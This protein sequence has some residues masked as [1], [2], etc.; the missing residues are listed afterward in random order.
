MGWRLPTRGKS[1]S[2]SLFFLLRKTSERE[3]ILIW[4]VEHH[5][6]QDIE[7]RRTGGFFLAEKRFTFAF[8]SIEEDFGR[9]R[10]RIGRT[11]DRIRQ[12]G[13]YGN[14]ARCIGHRT[15]LH[16]PLH[17]A[18]FLKT[19]RRLLVRCAF[20]FRPYSGARALPGGQTD[21]FISLPNGSW[22]LAPAHF[23]PHTCQR[24][25]TIPPFLPYASSSGKAMDKRPELPCLQN[26]AHRLRRCCILCNAQ[27]YSTA[28]NAV[29]SKGARGL[30][31][32]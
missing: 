15:A 2:P 10:N 26:A 20:R 31:L 9:R 6:T 29:R 13:A 5:S 18:A 28:A 17:G 14:T 16:Q 7:G 1:A 24:L 30:I 27:K 22:N 21:T 23:S 4:R 3:R 8:L 12:C 32:L 25:C 19:D 11:M